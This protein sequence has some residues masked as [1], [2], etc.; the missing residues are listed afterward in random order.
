MYYLPREFTKVK[1]IIPDSKPS[2][3][4]ALQLTEIL[5]NQLTSQNS[6][7]AASGEF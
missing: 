3:S 4:A 6:F 2:E 7:I 5:S 1:L